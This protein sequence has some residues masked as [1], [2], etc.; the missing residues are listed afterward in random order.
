MAG[1]IT[2]TKRAATTELG[3]KVCG[4]SKAP[5]TGAVV[6]KQSA[7][8]V[9]NEPPFEMDVDAPPDLLSVL[10]PSHPRPRL[11]ARLHSHSLART[12]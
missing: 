4:C 6:C 12:R 9:A 7:L 8:R 10:D 11:R 2:K 5:W 3:T 1:R